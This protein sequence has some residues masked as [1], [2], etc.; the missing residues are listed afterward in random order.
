MPRMNV[1]LCWNLLKCELLDYTS[2][3]VVTLLNRL[4]TACRHNLL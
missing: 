1:Q 2:V 3:L 4:S